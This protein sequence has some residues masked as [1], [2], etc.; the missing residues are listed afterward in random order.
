MKEFI[1]YKLFKKAF[2]ISSESIFIIFN[3]RLNELRM[4]IH[5]EVIIDEL[6]IAS[7]SSDES[8]N[9]RVRLTG[10]AHFG[11]E[12]LKISATIVWLKT[13]QIFRGY[14][15]HSLKNTSDTYCANQAKIAF[16]NAEY[17]KCLEYL[18]L[19]SQT[20]QISNKSVIKL[21]NLAIQYQS[22]L[23]KK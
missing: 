15:I 22:E 19:I 7:A 4:D 20:Y 12:I 3:E 6:S 14:F 23:R 18:L 9:R 8:G 1:N 11:P 5:P 2:N 16:K 13:L 21:K 10:R 17:D